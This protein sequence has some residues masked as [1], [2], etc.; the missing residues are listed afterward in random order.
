MLKRKHKIERLLRALET[1]EGRPASDIVE[2][3]RAGTPPASTCTLCLLNVGNDS[4]VGDCA[5]I[6]AQ[7]VS[8][9]GFVKKGVAYS[10]AVFDSPESASAALGILDDALFD[11]RGIPIL[12][13]GNALSSH[14]PSPSARVIHAMPALMVP[15][16]EIDTLTDPADILREIPGLHVLPDF[17]TAEE[18]DYLI[19]G[20]EQHPWINLSERQVQHHG[21]AFDYNSNHVDF[22]NRTGS[23]P[24]WCEF[25]IRKMDFAIK[26]L[27]E[28]HTNDFSYRGFNQLTLNKYPPGS[29]ISPHVDT[30][31]R[32]DS[33]ITSLSLLS[34][35]Q[36][37]FRTLYDNADDIFARNSHHKVVD[38]WLPRRSIAFMSGFVRFG[39]EHGIRARS[40]DVV[41]CR[42]VERGA[43]VSMT[44]RGVR[45]GEGVA[46]ECGCGWDAVC[47]AKI[48][49]GAKPDRL[50]SGRDVETG[51]NRHGVQG[52]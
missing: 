4:G 52:Q 45:E 30:H 46:G 26:M 40:A 51:V 27:A 9:P 12:V 14:I 36:M 22:S 3:A 42:R 13:P 7:L 41:N 1:R 29:G 28:V 21:F 49:G 31:T 25:L 37:E 38:V 20:M 2:I 33:P 19:K 18:E 10:F 47:D 5:A 23:L 35:V 34:G 8:L 17:I 48:A 15:F 43:R 32:F 44:F 24:D 39:W 50:K 11:A 16:P 6:S